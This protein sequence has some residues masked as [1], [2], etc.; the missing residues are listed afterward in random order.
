MR[1]LEIVCGVCVTFFH[2]YGSACP[3]QTLE[4]V[5]EENLHV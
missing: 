5:S 2:S 1:A 3:N 4:N